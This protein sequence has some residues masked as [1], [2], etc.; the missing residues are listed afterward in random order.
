MSRFSIPKI[1]DINHLLGHMPRGA[2][3]KELA[4]QMGLLRNFNRV[5]TRN[6]LP[7]VSRMA[8]NRHSV[9]R[10]FSDLSQSGDKKFRRLMG[11]IVLT[12]AALSTGLYL[13]QWNEGPFATETQDSHDYVE[14]LL[15]VKAMIGNRDDY[16]TKLPKRKPFSGKFP[17][18]P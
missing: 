17:L 15:A 2:K 1:S 16:A 11:G 4:A 10:F 18:T 8:R 3:A 7:G 12:G 5:L 14:A 6:L 9:R 13:K